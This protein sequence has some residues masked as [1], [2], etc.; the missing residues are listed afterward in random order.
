MAASIDISARIA[1]L[2]RA[3]ERAKGLPEDTILDSQPMAKL[4]GVGWPSLR[5]WFDNFPIFDST[6]CFVRGDRGIA[7]AIKPL[8][9][10]EKL[11]EHFRSEREAR[12][13]RNREVAKQIGLEDHGEAPADL[14]ELAKQVNLTLTL[15]EAKE[16]QKGYI[17][18]AQFVDFISGYNAAT[19][20]GILGVKAQVDPTGA[21]PPEIIALID[22]HLRNVAVAARNRA[23]AYIKDFDARL[24]Q[25]GD[26]RNS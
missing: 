10:V 7:W 15:T 19:V 18:T 8:P 20:E 2:E 1:G 12:A 24:N 21:L 3:L 13:S 4:V 26:S 14:N 16:K 5:D 6:D 25:S 23:S 9:T 17:P 11:L 22:E